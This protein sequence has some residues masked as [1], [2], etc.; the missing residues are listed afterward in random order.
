MYMMTVNICWLDDYMIVPLEKQ[1]FS[2]CTVSI[3]VFA[4]LGDGFA[5]VLFK[6]AVHI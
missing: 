5:G 2:V 1:F 6:I 4:V 3:V